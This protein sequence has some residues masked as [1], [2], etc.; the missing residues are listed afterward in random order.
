MT[1]QQIRLW[2]PLAQRADLVVDGVWT[3]MAR[4]G[5]EHWV[6]WLPTGTDYLLSVDGGTPRPDPRSAWQP[7]GVHGPSRVFDTGA[8]QWADGDWAGIE[9][10]GSV[11]YEMHVGTFTGAGTLDAAIGRLDRT[12]AHDGRHSLPPAFCSFSMK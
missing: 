2:A 8:H 12:G 9:V 5:A 7:H 10:L 6:S 4:D 11:M 3:P 1:D